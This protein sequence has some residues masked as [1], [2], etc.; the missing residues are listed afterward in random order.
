MHHLGI[1]MHQLGLIGIHHL[2]DS[3]TDTIHV[4]SYINF[5][6]KPLQSHCN[7]LYSTYSVVAIVLAVMVPPHDYD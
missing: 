3:C 7:C 1:G 2:G 4:T 5:C 6:S